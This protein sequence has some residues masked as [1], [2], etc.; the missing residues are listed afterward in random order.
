MKRNGGREMVSNLD[1]EELTILNK[2]LADLSDAA[3]RRKTAKTPREHR[4]AAIK[5]LSGLI[6]LGQV[7]DGPDSVCSALDLLAALEGLDAGINHPIFK[8]SKRT[9]GDRTVPIDWD[10]HLATLSALVEYGSLYNEDKRRRGDKG[11]WMSKI[12]ATFSLR[13]G[14]L[15]DFRKDNMGIGPSIAQSIH[16]DILRKLNVSCLHPDDALRFIKDGIFRPP[17]K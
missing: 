5:N 3:S 15:A 4:T 1:A 7:F 13:T 17:A 9:K 6:G 16:D 12:E 14:Q 10:A 11:E 8:K 2:A